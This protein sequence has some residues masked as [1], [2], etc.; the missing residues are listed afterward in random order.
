MVSKSFPSLD[1]Y[2]LN[3]DCLLQIGVLAADVPCSFN[4]I[5][6][7]ILDHFGAR[8]LRIKA[9]PVSLPLESQAVKIITLR[10]RTENPVAKL[11]TD[12]LRARVQPDLKNHRGFQSQR[13]EC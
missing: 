8:R 12:Q 2:G 10:G 11:F 1:R 6:V 9:L 4:P 5:L 7:R 3:F 13:T